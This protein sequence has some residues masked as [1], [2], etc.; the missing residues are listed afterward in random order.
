MPDLAPLAGS[1]ILQVLPGLGA[2]GAERGCVDVAAAI[3]RAGGVAL[4]A[5]TGGSL[6]VE[7][8]AGGGTAVTLPLASKN[9]WVMHRNAWALAALIRSRRVNLVHARSRAPAWSAWMACRS[10]GVPFMTTF[11]AA[12]NYDNALK[13]FYNSVMARGRRVIAISDFIGSHVRDAYRVPPERLRVVPR[14]IDLAR[15]DPAEVTPQRVRILRDL[16]RLPDNQPVLLL[17]GR[18]T[19]PKGQAVLVKALALLARPEVHVL[20]VGPDRG[21]EFR[22]ELVALANRLGVI[23]RLRVEGS[24]PDLPAAYA[25]ADVVVVAS[26]QPEGFGRIAVEA[27]AMGRPLIATGIGALP[28]LVEDGGGTGWLVPPDDPGALAACLAKI[29]DLAPEAK[30]ALGARAMARV[31]PAY[32]VAQMTDATIAV[33]REILAEAGGGAD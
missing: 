10:T 16:Y 25:L 17:P 9:P 15:F 28:E 4:V 22:T 21:A 20:M 12:Y 5:S 32:D 24:C 3:V 31:R 13:K 1:V 33:Y 29:L 18:L 11:H 2:G 14:G 30:A 19:R 26:T 8:E 7:L 6:S 23:G 27:Q